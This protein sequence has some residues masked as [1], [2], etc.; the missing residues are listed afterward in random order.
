MLAYSAVASNDGHALAAKSRCPRILALGNCTLSLRRSATN[1]DFCSSVRV[2]LGYL[3][4]YSSAASDVYKRQVGC[5]PTDIADS[6]GIGVVSLAVRSHLCERS[7][8]MHRAI[9]VDD[10]VISD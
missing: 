1:A 5:Q 10:E 4:L 7:A 2:S 3:P 6:Y 8:K 9:A